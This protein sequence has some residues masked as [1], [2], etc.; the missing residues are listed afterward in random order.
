MTYTG[1]ERRKIP[2]PR[3]PVFTCPSCQGTAFKVSDSRGFAEKDGVQRLRVCLDCGFK[4]RT[5]EYRVD[6]PETT[7]SCVRPR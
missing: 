2:R 7:T 5:E 3:V 1:P 4:L 6:P